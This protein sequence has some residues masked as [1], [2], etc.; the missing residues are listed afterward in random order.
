MARITDLTD[1]QF[2]EVV[3]SSKDLVLVYFW[4]TW[5]GPCKLVTPILEEVG[6]IHLNRLRIYRLNVATQR[7]DM[8]RY[9]V[10]NVPTLILFKH[11]EFVGTK[12]G[13]ITRTQL[14][15]FL[16]GAL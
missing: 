11:G 3:L 2:D 6:A 4:A 13:A 5:C 15:A 16:E 14:L 9:D 1:D 8:V 7:A 10:R 12:V